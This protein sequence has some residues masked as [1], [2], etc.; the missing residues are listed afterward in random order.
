MVGMQQNMVM[1]ADVE[2]AGVKFT[3][4]KRPGVRLPAKADLRGARSHVR[5]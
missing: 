5:Q 4:G 3:N 1:H 2:K